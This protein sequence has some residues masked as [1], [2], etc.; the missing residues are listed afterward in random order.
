M[1]APP[2]TNLFGG[3]VFSIFPNI[4][5][6]ELLQAVTVRTVDRWGVGG[7]PPIREKWCDP[8]PPF[9]FL[10]RFLCDFTTGK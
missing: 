6:G 3:P 5:G 8:L 4:Y 2:F 10:A 7:G 9:L 1:I